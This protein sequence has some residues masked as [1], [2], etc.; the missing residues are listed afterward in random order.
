MTAGTFTY[1]GGHFYIWRD[2]CQ[3]H[4]VSLVPPLD[5]LRCR[6]EQRTEHK[7]MGVD[8]AKMAAGSYAARSTVDL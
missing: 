7:V 8:G 4:A 6:V 2:T 5:E 3:V 1:D